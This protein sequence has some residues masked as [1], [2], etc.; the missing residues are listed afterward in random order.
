[1]LGA[2]DRQRVLGA[3]RADLPGAEPEHLRRDP[4][5]GVHPVGHG[6]DRHLRRV[7]ARP[8]PGEHPPAHLAVQRGDAVG[9]LREPQ[10]HDGH[11]EA[12]RV[13]AGVGLQAEREDTLDV[14]VREFGA[15]TEV[16]GHQFPVEAVDARRY[17]RVRG[18][19]RARPYGLQRGRE[20]QPPRGQFMDALQ[21]EEARVP[22]V[23]VEHL[24]LRVA[25]EPAV[26]AHRPYSADAQ[27]HLLEQPVL[28][29]A[30]VQPVGDIALA[31]VVLLHVRVEEQ[32]RHPADLGLP[33]VR[34][35]GAPAGQGEGDVGGVAVGLAE[36]GQR[37]LVGVE[38]RVVLLLPALA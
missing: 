10:P 37:Q 4:G 6:R 1:M 21:A 5:G 27:Q 33:D 28:A 16:T 20:L 13:A 9:A 8:Q 29:A 34:A 35:Q 18:E 31:R 15:R 23:G 30:A 11:V 12:V 2:A 19:D 3:A 36:E 17:G 24:G 25:G 14:D 38:Q 7:E 26:R 22:L 32:Q